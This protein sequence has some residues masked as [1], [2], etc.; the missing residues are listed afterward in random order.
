MVI[1]M[2]KEMQDCEVTVERIIGDKD[3]T[4]IEQLSDKNTWRKLLEIH[5]LL[6][7]S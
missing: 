4:T 1:D 2:V 3:T 6:L 5:F 7:R